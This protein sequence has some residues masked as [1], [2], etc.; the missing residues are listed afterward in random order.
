MPLGENRLHRQWFLQCTG[1]SK[2]SKTRKGPAAPQNQGPITQKDV[3]Q[4]YIAFHWR[5]HESFLLNRIFL[6]LTAYNW[7]QPKCPSIGEWIDHDMLNS[8]N[9]ILQ[10]NQNNAHCACHRNM[11]QDGW[12]SQTQCLSERRQTQKNIQLALAK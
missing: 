5:H 3:F 8:C 1:L 2:S 12:T 9:G 7:R 4:G 11:R 6:P 10:S